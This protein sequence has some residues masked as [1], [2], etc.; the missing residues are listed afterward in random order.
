MPAPANRFTAHA[1][2]PRFRL[3]LTCCALA[4]LLM[5]AVIASTSGFGPGWGDPAL[6]PG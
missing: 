3:T 1:S 6:L 2:H 5:M 4:L